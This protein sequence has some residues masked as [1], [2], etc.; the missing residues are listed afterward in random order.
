MLKHFLYP[1]FKTDHITYQNNFMIVMHFTSTNSCP[2]QFTLFINTQFRF[3]LYREPL[4]SRV[5][6]NRV[7]TKPDNRALKSHT[8]YTDSRR[9]NNKQNRTAN[10]Q[11]SPLYVFEDKEE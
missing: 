5:D 6:K 11:A 1:K 4:G 9:I 8:I 7:L 2:P 10:Q 3:P